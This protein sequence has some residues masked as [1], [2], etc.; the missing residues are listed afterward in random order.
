M[1]SH[2][3]GLMNTTGREVKIMIRDLGH[4]PSKKNYHYP[5]KNGG[6][7][8]DKEIKVRMER[9]EN[10]ILFAL[11][12]ESQIIGSETHSECLKRLRMLLSGLLD[13]SIREVPAGSW[14]VEYVPKGDEG[15]LIEINI[16]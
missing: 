16:L 1:I 6:L 5:L 15:C 3:N 7:G 4:I 13:D 10:A 14:D 2:K 12:S 8:I 11:Y 9:I